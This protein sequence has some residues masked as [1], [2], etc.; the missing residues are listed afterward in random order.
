M[1]EKD[2]PKGERRY[3]IPGRTD[4][5]EMGGK[6]FLFMGEWAGWEVCDRIHIFPDGSVSGLSGAFDPAAAVAVAG[7][8]LRE[9]RCRTA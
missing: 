9:G 5:F 3:L 2:I 1:S 8:I 7:R 4:V 6:F